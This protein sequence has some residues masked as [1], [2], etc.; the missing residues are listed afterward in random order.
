MEFLFIN[1]GKQTQLF[2]NL[3]SRTQ[4]VNLHLRMSRILSFENNRNV[5][6]YDVVMVESSWAT[7]IIVDVV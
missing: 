3:I 1:S 6:S 2:R 4:L 5:L 7:A